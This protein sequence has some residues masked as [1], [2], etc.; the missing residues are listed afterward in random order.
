MDDPAIDGKGNVFAPA[1]Y[2]NIIMKLDSKTLAEKAR[3]TV[4]D[5]VQPTTVEYQ[6]HTKRLLVGCRGDKPILMALDPDSGKITATAPI[7]K[8]LDGLVVDEERHR[9][10]TSNGVDANLSVIA[11]DGPDSLRALGNV[12]TRPNAKIMQIDPKTGRLFI[13]TAEHTVLPP[14]KPGDAAPVTYHPN[15]FVVMTYK[16]Q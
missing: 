1:R 5:C 15:S 6:E 16:P 12:M 2:D 8:G 14:P 7:G 13:V 9:I 3:W 4:G 10:M 11:Q